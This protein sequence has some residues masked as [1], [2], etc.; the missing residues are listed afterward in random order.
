M[1]DSIGKS[2]ADSVFTI[3]ETKLF[4]DFPVSG[5]TIEFINPKTRLAQC[6]KNYLIKLEKK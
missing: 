2:Q 6:K 4:Y 1:T 5:L 3:K